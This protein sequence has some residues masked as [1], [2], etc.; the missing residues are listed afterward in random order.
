MVARECKKASSL[1]KG[2]GGRS[3]SRV[4][5]VPWS[6]SRS[7]RIHPDVSDASELHARVCDGEDD[8]DWAGVVSRRGAIGLGLLSSV[9]STCFGSW[10]S[11]SSSSSLAWAKEVD[12]SAE[13]TFSLSTQPQLRPQ[14]RKE[15]DALARA[16]SEINKNK[17]PGLLRL[18]FHDAGTYDEGSGTGGPNG[19]IRFELDRPESFG[20]KR[21]WRVV[22]ELK[23][24]V[25]AQSRLDIS[26]ADL[27]VVCGA[28]A[29]ET[30]GGPRIDVQLGRVDSQV[31]DGENMI[32]DENL[33]VGGLKDAFERMGFNT[34]ELVALS[35]SHAVGGKGYGDPLTFDNVYYKTL[36]EK[37]WLRKDEMS[38]MI[39]IKSDHVLMDDSEC[40]KFIEE[41][42]GN[43]EKFFAR[44][45]SSYAKLT[46][47]GYKVT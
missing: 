46:T 2:R 33:P 15:K 41:F 36:L 44:F 40:R 42:A 39:G 12:Q 9:S 4:N 28:W 14:T 43:Q 25:L 20:L 17:S 13:A 10:S 29:V 31:A 32:P 30:C 6:R 47:F 37:P 3:A 5:R 19:S 45:V 16:L 26:Y 7:K 38:Q 8:G 18:V 21:S 34:E 24:R 35:G 23:E 22:K 27:I 1:S 11:S